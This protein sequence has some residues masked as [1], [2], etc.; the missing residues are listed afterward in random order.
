MTRI[1]YTGNNLTDIINLLNFYINMDLIYIDAYSYIIYPSHVSFSFF[2]ENNC[3]GDTLKIHDE[4]C[5]TKHGY[6]FIDSQRK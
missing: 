2:K 1:E 3:Y 4:L 5:I 6:I